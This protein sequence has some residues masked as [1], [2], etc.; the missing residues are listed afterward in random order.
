MVTLECV[1]RAGKPPAEVSTRGLHVR[2]SQ[3]Q[4]FVTYLVQPL[5]PWGVWYTKHPFPLTQ[6]GAGLQHTWERI[7]FS[8]KEQGETNS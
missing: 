6:K 8:A 3:K 5:K 2:G 7:F 1:S 4:G